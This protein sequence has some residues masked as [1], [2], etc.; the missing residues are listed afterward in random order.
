MDIFSTVDGFEWDKGNLQKSWQKHK[1]HPAECEEVFFN[2]PLVVQQDAAHSAS[3][4]RY[5]LLGRTDAGRTLFA[6]FTIRGTKIRVISARDMS[7]K[8]SLAYDEAIKKDAQVQ[9]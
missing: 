9:E 6:V 7:R 5:Y 2:T 1:V 8:E 3:E 4:H